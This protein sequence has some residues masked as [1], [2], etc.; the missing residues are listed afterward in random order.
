MAVR[1]S[2]IEG[3]ILAI[4]RGMNACKET[5]EKCK[6]EIKLREKVKRGLKMS[7]RRKREEGEEGEE[8]E[9]GKKKTMKTMTTKKRRTTTRRRKMKTR[10]VTEEGGVVTE[11]DDDEEEEEE[12]VQEEQ[13]KQE[14]ESEEEKKIRVLLLR[15]IDGGSLQNMN[16]VEMRCIEKVFYDVEDNACRKTRGYDYGMPV[17]QWLKRRL[18][19]VRDIWAAPLSTYETAKRVDAMWRE[20]AEEEESNTNTEEA[21][22]DDTCVQD[23]ADPAQTLRTGVAPSP[24]AAEEEA[25]AA[26]RSEAEGLSR[27]SIADETMKETDDDTQRP[28]RTEA[29]AK[30]LKKMTTTMTTVTIV[31]NEQSHGDRRGTSGGGE[32]D[33]TQKAQPATVSAPSPMPISPLPSVLP[34][35][36]EPSAVTLDSFFPAFPT[37]DVHQTGV[38]EQSTKSDAKTRDS[39]E[40]RT[41]EVDNDGTALIT[42]EAHPHVPGPLIMTETAKADRRPPMS[43]IDL[44]ESPLSP[45]SPV[46]LEAAFALVS[47]TIAPLDSAEK[48]ACDEDA[49]FDVLVHQQP[50]ARQFASRALTPLFANAAAVGAGGGNGQMLS[51][52]ATAATSDDDKAD[53]GDKNGAPGIMVPDWL[54]END[55]NQEKERGRDDPSAGGDVGSRPLKPSRPVHGDSTS[56]R[57][58]QEL[59]AASIVHIEDEEEKHDGEKGERATT[60]TISEDAERKDDANVRGQECRAKEAPANGGRD[61]RPP[62][63]A[64]A[65][66][67]NAAANSEAIEVPSA[68][69][70]SAA[71]Y[72]DASKGADV[73]ARKSGTSMKSAMTA[74]LSPSAAADTTTT[75][76]TTM[77]N[78]AMP[79]SISDA[80]PQ[81][82]GTV[83]SERDQHTRNVAASSPNRSPDDIRRTNDGAAVGNAATLDV[84]GALGESEASPLAD[85]AIDPS[86]LV[87]SPQLTLQRRVANGTLAPVPS[88][89]SSNPVPTSQTGK[90][91]GHLIQLVAVQHLVAAASTVVR[92]KTAAAVPSPPHDCVFSTPPPKPASSGQVRSP[93]LMLPPALPSPASPFSPVLTASG[94]GNDDG[95]G[96][97]RG[98]AGGRRAQKSKTDSCIGNTLPYRSSMRGKTAVT[99]TTHSNVF[100][101]RSFPSAP[102]PALVTTSPSGDA[103]GERRGILKQAAGAIDY[104]EPA[105]PEDRQERMLDELAKN[106]GL[107]SRLIEHLSS[108]VGAHAGS[109]PQNRQQQQQRLQQ[110]QR[111][112]SSPPTTRSSST[113]PRGHAAVAAAAAVRSTSTSNASALAM[114]VA[115]QQRPASPMS[116]SPTL[117]ESWY[118]GAASLVCEGKVLLQKSRVLAPM[119]W[120][121]GDVD[122]SVDVDGASGRSP[123]NEPRDA[124]PK[125]AP[126]KKRRRVS[127]AEGN[128]LCVYHNHVVECA[129]A[130]DD[131]S[132]PECNGDAIM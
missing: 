117:P 38:N 16:M 119:S 45:A 24:P 116:L 60:M 99:T 51:S 79:A 93:P 61:V 12:E 8:E 132:P 113:R 70:D 52:S 30:T 95:I 13:G 129:A 104:D 124:P 115:A 89:S 130:D 62:P 58:A 69:M 1:G 49:P 90:S 84:D 53:G 126:L 35:L 57:A 80:R 41:D 81:E 59:N 91:R 125:L 112:K 121:N 68:T 32:A 33:G 19:D 105:T 120:A 87:D 55:D 2:V 107:I 14:E 7:V 100:R 127:F 39:V 86:Q 25:A 10:R 111:R 40:K 128:A 67:T 64:A 74:S 85:G 63:L 54:N 108:A 31:P 5:L 18:L 122:V 76:T 6:E 78:R 20:M 94:D 114:P 29:T 50:R 77:T 123:T 34:L 48:A 88:T 26:A 4:K 92:S 65:A 42:P 56:E 72:P 102:L 110:Q 23:K 101:K 15:L 11:D 43:D 82:P 71:E 131:N 44:P 46:D 37:A 47:D 27:T 118:E 73:P 9:G 83:V 75:T 97:S 21:I 98:G 17:A 28:Q 96:G 109:E 66:A 106:R 3:H 36:E 22:T 103:G